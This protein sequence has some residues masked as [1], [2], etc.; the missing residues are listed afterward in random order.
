MLGTLRRYLSHSQL[1][2]GI[3][4]KAALEAVLYYQDALVFFEA[5]K[6]TVTGYDPSGAALPVLKKRTCISFG[7]AIA[8]S[9]AKRDNATFLVLVMEADSAN[10]EQLHR[11]R[12]GDIS[13]EELEEFLTTATLET[14]YRVYGLNGALHYSVK[15]PKQMIYANSL[16]GTPLIIGLAMQKGKEDRG[17]I[18]P[19]LTFDFLIDMQEA[20]YVAPCRLIAPPQPQIP[21][22]VDI[23]AYPAL[24]RI[25]VKGRA[26]ASA[27]PVTSKHALDELLASK[28]ISSG[29]VIYTVAAIHTSL[30]GTEAFYR[31]YDIKFTQPSKR[32]QSEREFLRSITTS[33]HVSLTKVIMA[34]TQIIST[35]AINAGAP[36]GS[37]LADV[38]GLLLR[39]GMVH[40]YSRKDGNSAS[41][42]HVQVFSHTFTRAFCANMQG[43]LLLLASD[44]GEL[45]MLGVDGIWNS[46]ARIEEIKVQLNQ[47]FLGDSDDVNMS[48]EDRTNMQDL[49]KLGIFPDPENRVSDRQYTQL[50]TKKPG[51]LAVLFRLEY[52]PGISCLAMTKDARTTLLGLPGTRFVAI[53]AISLRSRA[54]VSA[55]QDLLLNRSNTLVNSREQIPDVENALN[56]VLSLLRSRSIPVDTI[57]QA[58]NTFF[59]FDETPWGFKPIQEGVLGEEDIPQELDKSVSRVLSLMASVAAPT[60]ESD[61]N[62]IAM[63]PVGT[64]IVAKSLTSTIPVPYQPDPVTMDGFKTPTIEEKGFFLDEDVPGDQFQFCDI[65]ESDLLQEHLVDTARD[66][67]ESGMTREDVCRSF[68]GQLIEKLRSSA[69][70][71]TVKAHSGASQDEDCG[72]EP[73]RG[74]ENVLEVQSKVLENDL[75]AIPENRISTIPD[76]D[77]EELDDLK[78]LLGTL[79]AA[80]TEA[81][82][83]RLALTT[84]RPELPTLHTKDD[85][86]TL[87]AEYQKNKDAAVVPANRGLDSALTLLLHDNPLFVLAACGL[88]GPCEQRNY[89][90]SSDEQRPEHNILM[91]APYGFLFVIQVRVAVLEP[92]GL[93]REHISGRMVCEILNSLHGTSGRLNLSRSDKLARHVQSF[94]T[95]VYEEDFA[96]ARDLCSGC[97]N[98]HSEAL[99]S[100][101]HVDMPPYLFIAGIHDL[102]REFSFSQEL[103]TSSTPCTASYRLVGAI[104]RDFATIYSTDPLGK[105]NASDLTGTTSPT[106]ESDVLQNH[107]YSVYVRKDMVP[108]ITV[109][110]TTLDVICAYQHALSMP[111]MS[112]DTSDAEIRIKDLTLR[113]ASLQTQVE[114]RALAEEH[115]RKR[116]ESL[117]MENKELKKQVAELKTDLAFEEQNQRQL[118]FAL[119]P[120]HDGRSEELAAQLADLK[121]ELHRQEA[122]HKAALIELEEAHRAAR[123]QDRAREVAELGMYDVTIKHCL[124]ALGE[125]DLPESR[126]DLLLLLQTRCMN[127]SSNLSLS[128]AI[129]GQAVRSSQQ[130][131]TRS[132]LVSRSLASSVEGA[133]QASEFEDQP[134]TSRHLLMSTVLPVL[135]FF[136]GMVIIVVLAMAFSRN[137]VV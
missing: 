76:A 7:D 99:S 51:R 43:S 9:V 79:S 92:C 18:K 113:V 8:L 56:A 119:E 6:V 116:V 31:E 21:P 110:P 127:V 67:L 24:F 62:S 86:S 118:S 60:L 26:L 123:D 84:L 109:P 16:E 36:P 104:T 131:L 35:M 15:T 48:P 10:L 91:G 70:A 87:I 103:S 1:E 132:R 133:W 75:L 49:L 137:D 135:C 134:P 41:L 63:G 2:D 27:N 38:F 100:V 106:L 3:S 108:S 107:Y 72:R 82:F 73:E 80:W 14:Q 102:A 121:K 61:L 39:D 85:G 40:I 20:G 136:I 44:S 58:I 83:R 129:G 59:A 68:G 77:L 89:Y 19:T 64:G 28:D 74:S 47:L 11:I 114:S 128:G 122:L 115:A 29:T 130:R 17:I 42:A 30:S 97:G 54:L 120:S 105:W 25:K 78:R 66:L 22:L 34:P 96:E 37:L 4:Q 5:G 46:D 126:R 101:L 93:V 52:K 57:Q 69:L 112:F 117:N 81:T 94:I 23:V 12:S 13:H 71:S 98:M 50:G 45:A 55:Y 90:F 53:P 95:A 32:S 125:T 111:P 33:V 65:R 124:R 88:R